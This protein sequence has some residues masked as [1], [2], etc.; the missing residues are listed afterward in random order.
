[1]AAVSR[2]RV[3]VF[4]G[5]QLADEAWI[6]AGA[7]DALI[8]VDWVNERHLAMVQAAHAGGQPWLVELHDAGRPPDD[9]CLRIGT[10]TEGMI[11]PLPA[12]GW[13]GLS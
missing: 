2:L 13:E 8:Q 10:D 7:P 6:D 1:M 4:I 9:C 11:A 3:R 5:G 12:A